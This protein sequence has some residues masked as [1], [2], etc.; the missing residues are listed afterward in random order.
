M[1]SMFVDIVRIGKF[2]IFAAFICVE[3][4]CCPAVVVL[5]T[6]INGVPLTISPRK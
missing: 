5:S 2:T 6:C 4:S 3:V 1:I